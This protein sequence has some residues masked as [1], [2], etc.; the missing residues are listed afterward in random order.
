MK[1]FINYIAAS[2]F[3]IFT[4]IGTIDIGRNH[5]MG[6]HIPVQFQFNPVID[7]ELL[8]CR[9]RL[10]SGGVGHEQGIKISFIGQLTELFFDMPD[11]LGT[12]FLIPWH[13][14]SNS[15]SISSV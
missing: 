7:L 4:A 12:E 13:V 2:D 14:V 9:V 5:I 3:D 10:H 11:A 8:N 6:I 15:S 1:P